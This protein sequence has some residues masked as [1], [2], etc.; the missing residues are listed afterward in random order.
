MFSLRHRIHG[1]CSLYNK[2][3]DAH[4]MTLPRTQRMS[5][6]EHRAYLDNV[7]SRTLQ[8]VAFKEGGNTPSITLQ[9]I[10]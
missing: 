7:P 2:A 10:H 8:R 4:S 3:E 5:L 6:L 9:R 1:Y